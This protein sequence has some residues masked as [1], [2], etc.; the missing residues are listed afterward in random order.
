MSKN[1]KIL[2]ID[3]AIKTCQIIYSDGNEVLFQYRSP[4]SEI[5]HAEVFFEQLALLQNLRADVF[6]ELDKV[7]VNIGPGRFNALRVGLGF[8]L[9]LCS[10]F[11]T[12]FYTIT[13]FDILKQQALQSGV[14]D[15]QSKDFAIF[16]KWN[17]VYYLSA[18]KREMELVSYDK[19]DWKNTISLG[20][21][22]QSSIA[23][24]DY[25]QVDNIQALESL[26]ILQ[27]SL[28]SVEP[29]YIGHQIS[30]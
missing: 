10:V 15:L 6:R 4:I 8:A 25:L 26:S 11:K 13:S 1:E 28:Q 17:H 21:L 3:T 16:A 7:I 19:V 24:F 12:S 22:D 18:G 2:F 23:N 30:M 5:G 9:T 27:S 20:V 29:I 14:I